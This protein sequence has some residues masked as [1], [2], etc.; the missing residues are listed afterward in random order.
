M[1]DITK[2]PDFTGIY[3]NMRLFPMSE[4]DANADKRLFMQYV[5]DMSVQLTWRQ[6]SIQQ[7]Q[8]LFM[9]DADFEITSVI[10]L[11]EERID[12]D[13][14]ERLQTRLHAHVDVIQRNLA[15]KAETRRQLEMAKLISFLI[16]FLIGM[17]RRNKVPDI[18]RLLPPLTGELKQEMKRF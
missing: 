13:T 17:R 10:R 18:R 3:N 4:H 15:N 11:G 1:M 7:H 5:D 6:K 12:R 2:D 9:I 16:P 8:N 14:F